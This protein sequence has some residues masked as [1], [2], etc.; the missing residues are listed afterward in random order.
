MTDLLVLG[1]ALW[2]AV[3]TWHHGSIFKRSRTYFR[4]WKKSRY[5]IV[6]LLAELINCMFCLSH[7]V[8]ATLVVA[9]LA[10]GD[11][12]PVRIIV[13]TLAVIRL[14]QLGNDLTHDSN[15]SPPSDVVPEDE[16]FEFVDP[17]GM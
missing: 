6:R 4:S 10:A 3:E 13:W 11:Y 12:L 14:A 7:W 1:L 2:Q 17:S 8:G 15:R 5:G 9:Y 16:Q